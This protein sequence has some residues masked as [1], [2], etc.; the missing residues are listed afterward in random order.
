VEATSV[1]IANEAQAAAWDGHEGDMWT[2]HADRYDRAGRRTWER[3]LAGGHI[4]AGDDVLDVG[5]GTG[6]ATRDVAKIASNGQVLGIDLSAR[7]LELARARTEAEALTNVAYVQGD[8]Q[9][10][11]FSPARHDIAMSCYGGMFFGDP[12]A[13]YSNIANA[14]RPGGRLVLLAWR[15]LA[16]NEWLVELRGALALGRELPVP[17]PE[18]PTPFS[19]AEPVRVR[20]LLGAAGYRDVEFEAIDEALCLGE[21]PADAMAFIETMGIV[22]GLLDGIDA[23]GRSEAFANLRGLCE[24]HATDDGVLLDSASWC[25]TA[26]RS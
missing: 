2:E 21:D 16:A 6:R 5:C 26:V 4:H 11:P 20:A 19:L 9:V 7:M 10:H 13:A 14:L 1:N 23:D 3:F 15:D 18:A 22:E 24:A 12:V 8:A 25:I 17:P